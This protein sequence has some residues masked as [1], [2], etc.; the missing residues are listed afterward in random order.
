[1]QLE[2]MPLTSNGKIDKRSLPSPGA[3]RSTPYVA[4]RNEMEEKMVAIWS[5]VLEVE[6]DKI[7]IRDNFFELGGHSLK[8]IRIVVRVHEQ[9]DVEIDLTALFN[10]PTIEALVSEMENLL[11][12][13]SSNENTLITDKTIV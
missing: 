11:W 6:Q 1:M 13:R 2:K 7:G 12:L 5:D 9:F 10:E 4:P 8:A 3:E